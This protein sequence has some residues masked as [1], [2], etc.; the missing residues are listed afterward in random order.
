[1]IKKK[2]YAWACDYSNNS[3][4]GNL[5]R[6]FSKTLSKNFKVVVRTPSN[7]FFKNKIFNYKYVSP[8]IGIVCC[9]YYFFLKKKVSYINYLPMWNFILFLFLPPSTILGPITGGSNYKNRNLF[10]RKY[11]F[12]IFY[13]TSEIALFLRNSNIIFATDLLKKY[14]NKK[15]LK[16]SRFNFVF[17][18]YKKKRFTKKNI[19]FVIYYRKHK[20]KESY[21]PIKFIKKLLDLKYE[22]HVVGNNLNIK[23]IKNHGFISNR[24][25]NNL[26]S[27][28][29]YS[30]GSGESIYTL[31]VMECI[32][33]HVKIIMDKDYNH[34]IKFYK[35]Y[36][37][38]MNFNSNK[39]FKKISYS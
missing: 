20:N 24:K 32:N 34:N 29:K 11:L 36:F 18:A 16:G 12:P 33:N 25:L 9:W 4:E 8:F 19:D 13:K 28:S 3:G 6:L 2:L 26:L 7:I 15:I 39:D 38:K 27:S 22:I 10:F 35:K 21:F 23:G 37:I 5:A 31:F 14:L 30:L 17:E 1:M